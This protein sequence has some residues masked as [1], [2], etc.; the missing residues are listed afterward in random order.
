MTSTP[1]FSVIIPLYN[2]EGFIADTLKSALHQTYQ[3][4]EILIVNDGSTD[5]SLNI[6]SSF[7]DNRITILNQDNKGL[8][9][10]RNNGIKH[11]Q[12]DYIAFLDAD[13][14]W[15]TDYLETQYKL[16][17]N[18]NDEFVFATNI[19]LL[20][21][22]L[23]PN[24]LPIPY[25]SRF[26]K[27]ITNYFELCENIFGPSSLVLR[28]E[29]MATIGVFNEA[30]TYGEGDEF[31]IKCFQ[32]YNLV[33]YTSPKVLYRTGIKNQL[34]APNKNS[35]RII[36]D[37]DVYLKN[38]TNYALKKYIDF[39]HYKLV[40]LYKM[41]LNHEKVKFYKKKITPEN[42]NLKRRIKYYLP[43]NLFYFFKSV[44]LFLK[45]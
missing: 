7:K 1:F 27:K 19:N 28:K 16:I 18:Y 20:K 9:A 2:K 8:S 32:N 44:Y 17:S 39:V 38:N 15:K 13:D 33:Y 41:E 25:S 14:L 43:T 10:A 24:L 36:P 31:F 4:F 21:P 5:K 26:Q 11:A 3:N 35:K 45:K 34:T 12:A 23:T 40:V 42:L 6:A 37:Y 22:K 30:I 29:V